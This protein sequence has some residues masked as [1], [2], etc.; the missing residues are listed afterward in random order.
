MRK[1]AILSVLITGLVSQPL[2]GGEFTTA[3]FAGEF[4]NL[5]VG[6]RS[7]G[8]GGAY[9]AVARDVTAGY[10]NPAGLA[11]LETPQAMLMHTSQFAGLV[12]YNYGGFGLPVSGASSLGLSIMRVGVDDIPRTALPNPELEIGETYVDEDGRVVR[13]IPY[14]SGQFSSTDYAFYLTYSKRISNDFAFGGNVKFLNRN[15]DEHSAW[16]LGFDVGFLFNPVSQL[17]VGINLQDV[18]STLVAWDTGRR[19]LITPTLRTGVTYPLQ[20]SFLGGEVQPSVDFVVQFDNREQGTLAHLGR[21]SLD[22]K[23][24]FE[25]SYRE[26]FAFRVGSSEVGSFAAGAGLHFSNLHID[27]AFLEHTLGSTHRISVKLTFG[28]RSFGGE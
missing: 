15:L 16:G 13:N 24:G 4:L 3:K 12:N 26:A 27:Y 20:M 25:Y 22:M 17:I 21:S 28:K 14:V 9:V 2:V 1:I 5:G 11:Y 19:E 6:A 7:L 8:M 18:T 23:L 10:W